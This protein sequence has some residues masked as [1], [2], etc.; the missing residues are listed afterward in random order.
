MTRVPGPAEAPGSGCVLRNSSSVQY[1]AR[2]H[3]RDATRGGDNRDNE[4]GTAFKLSRLQGGGYI[5]T[6]LHNSVTETTGF[7]IAA[8]RP[9][10]NRSPRNHPN[11]SGT[12][13]PR[14]VQADIRAISGSCRSRAAPS[15]SSRSYC[16]LAN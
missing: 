13:H 11:S 8:D 10:T 14:A 9:H 12:P 2:N 5:E 3:H 6:V 15:R 4:G 7:P 1:W 16:N